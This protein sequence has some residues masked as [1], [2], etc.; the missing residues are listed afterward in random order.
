MIEVTVVKIGL[1]RYKAAASL[2]ETVIVWG[3]GFTPNIAR[4]RC[5]QAVSDYTEAFNA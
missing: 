5:L 2:G 4:R 3:L 1:L